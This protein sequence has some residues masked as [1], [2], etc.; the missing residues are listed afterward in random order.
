MDLPDFVKESVSKIQI[1][2]IFQ[3]RMLLR[4][5]WR[6]TRCTRN[7]P[8]LA[9][10]ALA[11]ARELHFLDKRIHNRALRRLSSALHDVCGARGHGQS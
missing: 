3:A 6:E 11:Q 10:R 4:R 2:C 7:A 9:S 8:A 1:L 5:T